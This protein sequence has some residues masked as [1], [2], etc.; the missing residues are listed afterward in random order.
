MT[1]QQSAKL[2]LGVLSVLTLAVLCVSIWRMLGTLTETPAPQAAP[3]RVASNAPN[4]EAPP[5]EAVRTMR[6]FP[7]RVGHIID[8]SANP[9]FAGLA[10]TK[11]SVDLSNAPIDDALAGFAQATSLI[12]PDDFLRNARSREIAPLTLQLKDAPL[13]EGVLQLCTRTGTTI[14]TF[15]ATELTLQTAPADGGIGPWSIAGPFAVDLERIEVNAQLDPRASQNT[16]ATFRASFFAE[17]N[18]HVIAAKTVTF[19]TI[20]DENGVAIGTVGNAS[21]GRSSSLSTAYML[22]SRWNLAPGHGRRIPKLR[23]VIPVTIANK[24]DTIQVDLGGADPT[25]HS[26]NGM[27]FEISPMSVETGSRYSVKVHMTRGEADPKYMQQIV[28]MVMDAG[29]RMVTDGRSVRPGTTA[30]TQTGAEDRTITFSISVAQGG[31]PPQQ[32]IL[33]VPTDMRDVRVPFEFTD[34]PLP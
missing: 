15:N 20:N 24:T 17:P 31:S 27:K 6:S 12:G 14:S 13:L 9:E 8:V 21:L 28:T 16:S 33:D 5:I 3:A 29:P 11:I 34:L 30:I 1:S 7:A 23:G 10:A 25:T 2:I 26:V 32:F 4:R 18:A 19:E 22:T